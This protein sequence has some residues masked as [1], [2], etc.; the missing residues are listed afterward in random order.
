MRNLFTLLEVLPVGA[1]RKKRWR[2]V[3]E[4]GT[5]KIVLADNV[6]RGRTT[7]CGCQQKKLA[8]K[9][10]RR[11]GMSTTPTY[12]VWHTMHR[13]CKKHIDYV[14]RGISV[15]KRWSDFANFYADMGARPPGLTLERKNNAKGYSPSNC[16]WATYAEQ[17]ANTRHN[18]LLTFRGRTQCAASWARELGMCPKTLRQRLYHGWSVQDTLTVPLGGRR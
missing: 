12:R 3:C 6:N 5:V 8:A 10:R 1:D 15:C 16:V 13:R 18:R 11:H 9:A 2:V 4:C 7:S 14:T 17:N